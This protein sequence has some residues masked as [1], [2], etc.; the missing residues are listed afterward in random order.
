MEK[1]EFPV[2]IIGL[3]PLGMAIADMLM[4]QGMA[5]IGYRR[6][7]MDEFVAVG[8]VP[9]DTPADLVGRAE[10]VLDC[11]PHEE[12]L[13]SLFDGPF[14][15]MD[16]VEEGQII[17]SLASHELENKERFARL[18]GERGGIVL[19]GEVLGTPDLLASRDAT[20]FLSG[21]A[22]AIARVKPLIERLTKHQ[23]ELGDFGEATRMRLSAQGVA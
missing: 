6:S 3:A 20:I 23:V 21:D 7:G 18:V 16:A 2:G 10:V 1:K 17:V 22:G 11:L 14:S 4:S 8:G 12:A 13:L 15:I 19:D 9:A 5:V